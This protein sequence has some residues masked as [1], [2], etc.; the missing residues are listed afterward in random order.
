MIRKNLMVL[1]LLSLFLS[2]GVADSAVNF[3]QYKTTMLTKDREINQTALNNFFS[4]GGEKT[5]DKYFNN[6]PDGEE[7]ND[8]ADALYDIVESKDKDSGVSKEEAMEGLKLALLGDKAEIV[9]DI[10]EE[11][12]RETKEGKKKILELNEKI[13][14]QEKDIKNL[15]N[16]IL[17][18]IF[19]PVLGDTLENNRMDG[20]NLNYV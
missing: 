15:D 4:N 9:P 14:E 12:M 7:P 2:V 1:V 20:F 17:L 16:H 10:T 18:V 5:L 11:D 6:L 19:F 8:I 13:K 3:E